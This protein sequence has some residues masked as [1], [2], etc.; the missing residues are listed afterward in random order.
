MVGLGAG[1]RSYSAKLHYSTE[2][3]VGR[4]GVLD[5]IGDFT[6]RTDEQFSVADYGCELELDEQKRRYVLKSLLRCDGLDLSEYRAHFQTDVFE[7][8][9]QLNELFDHGLTGRA[10]GRLSL[11]EQGLEFSDVI[12]TWLSSPV[13]RERMSEFALR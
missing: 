10:V 11:N 8:F 12:G 7:D 3:A 9:S 5:V 6:R 2:Y 1:A 4:A 13:V